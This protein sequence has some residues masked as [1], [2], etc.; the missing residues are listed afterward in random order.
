MYYPNTIPGNVSA[1][2]QG[3]SVTQQCAVCRHEVNRIY[4]DNQTGICSECIKPAGMDQ[5]SMERR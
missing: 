2:A 3:D 5:E 1:P 4:I